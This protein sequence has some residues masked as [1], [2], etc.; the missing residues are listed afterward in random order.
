MRWVIGDVHGC[1]RELERLLKAIRYDEARDE[2][3]SIGD[4]VNKGPDSLAVL[5]LWQDA[6]GCGVLG[7]HDAY[8]LS[9]ALGWR[10]RRHDTLDPLFASADG[11]E[12]LL[13]LRDWPLLVPLAS[14]GVPVWLVHAGLHP[15][16]TDLEAVAGRINAPPHD[17]SWFASPE[18]AFA[19]RARCCTP[20]GAMRDATGPP[21]ECEPP[22]RPWDAYY[23][24]SSTVVHGHWAARGA[25]RTGRVVGLDSGCVYGGALSA[26]CVEEARLVQVGG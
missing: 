19:L 17:K 6:G 21:S 26:W 16:W 8:A 23:R 5:R 13:R 9:V 18:T 12:R 22:F 10:P 1:V 2:L 4:L 20:D 24:G 7:N 3:W 15:G 11:E 14:D 25:H